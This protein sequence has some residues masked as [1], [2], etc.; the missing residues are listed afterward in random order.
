MEHVAE[1]V[2]ERDDLV[3]GEQR[4]SVGGRLGQVGDDARHRRRYDPSVSRRPGTRSNAAAW[5]NLPSRGWRSMWAM[6]ILTRSPVADGVRE[7]VRMPH[8]D[9]VEAPVLEAEH[10]AGDRRAARRA[11]AE[12]EVRRD[13]VGIDAVLGLAQLGVVVA[14]V[15]RL[16]LP[17]AGVAGQEPGHHVDL[18]RAP[19]VS[20]RQQPVV[21]AVDRLGVV[22]HLL[23]HRV[24]GPRRAGRTARPCARAARPP[25]PAAAGWFRPPG[26]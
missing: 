24:V 2:E 18:G 8:R 10:L 21:E 5:L 26:C 12:R 22:G 7:D 4:R 23:V 11:P 20:T 15:P 25:R 9:V 17:V 19:S 3:V 16:Q 1:L 13:L 6:A 14:P